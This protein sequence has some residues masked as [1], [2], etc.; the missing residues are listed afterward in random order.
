MVY[1]LVKRSRVYEGLPYCGPS[2]NNLPAQADTLEAAQKMQA[3]LTARNPV[4]W[5]IYVAE[6]PEK[7]GMKWVLVRDDSAHD[8]CIPAELVGSFYRWVDRYLDEVWQGLDFDE[9]RLGG[10]RSQLEFENPVY[11]GMSWEEKLKEKTK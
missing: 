8:Y 11:Q 2:S 4:G 3:E 1:H 6:K 9:F 7:V 10:A 5:D